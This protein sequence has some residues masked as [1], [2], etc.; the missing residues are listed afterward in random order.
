MEKRGVNAADVARDTGV[1]KSLISR[2]MNTN[3]TPDVKNQEI[4]AAY[5]G[6]DREGL[7]RDPADDWMR[8]MFQRRRKLAELLSS[9]SD[10]D[11]DRAENV[12][13]AAFPRSAQIN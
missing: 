2:W 10:E 6:T 3:A 11:L 4:L 1:D 12:I 13:L 8:R 5:F 9:M 7:F